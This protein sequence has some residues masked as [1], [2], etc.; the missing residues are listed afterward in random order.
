MIRCLP[1]ELN[2]RRAQM[3]DRVQTR[4]AAASMPG[5]ERGRPPRS[6]GTAPRGATPDGL[7]LLG[8]LKIAL[9]QRRRIYLRYMAL[10]TEVTS[11]HQHV[12]L[13]A[14]AVDVM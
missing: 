8:G 12:V 6:R 9:Y 4:A 1:A 14:V 10:A 13:L 3:T 7:V 2:R 5:P 11:T